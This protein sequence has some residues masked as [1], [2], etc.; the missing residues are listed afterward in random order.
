MYFLYSDNDFLSDDV[1]FEKQ[2]KQNKHFLGQFVMMTSCWG[3]V[4]LHWIPS[5]ELTG[6][7]MK[8]KLLKYIL[9]QCYEYTQFL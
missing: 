4:D 2:N 7:H 6:K 3:Q 5:T 8:L 9:K 1:H